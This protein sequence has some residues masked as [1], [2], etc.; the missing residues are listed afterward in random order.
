MLRQ[1]QLLTIPTAVSI[2]FFDV[3]FFVIADIFGFTEREVLLGVFAGAAGGMSVLVAN[4]WQFARN[5][6]IQVT[7]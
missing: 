4:L 5:V 3:T 2:A 1:L 6:A 7:N